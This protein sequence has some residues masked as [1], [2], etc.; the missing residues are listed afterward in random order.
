MHAVLSSQIIFYQSR[1]GRLFVLKFYHD[2]ASINFSK[3]LTYLG[4]IKPENSS[5]EFRHPGIGRKYY[6]YKETNFSR[7]TFL[8]EDID[9][10]FPDTYFK[11]IGLPVREFQFLSQ[12]LSNFLKIFFKPSANLINTESQ[13]AEISTARTQHSFYPEQEAIEEN[14]EKY[15]NVPASY[16]I[17]E[18]YLLYDKSDLVKETFL[19]ALQK[20]L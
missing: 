8:S 20:N 11:S 10:P 18:S 5:S 2:R 13:T 7:H 17:N 3:H 1:A 16:F 19:T 14:I 9:W 12:N 15:K 4:E 6:S